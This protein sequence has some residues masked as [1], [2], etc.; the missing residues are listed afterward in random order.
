M[1]PDD[2]ATQQEE[3][4]REMAL[5]NRKLELPKIGRCYN[6]GEGIKPNANFCDADCRKDYERRTENAKGK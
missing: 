1:S 4:L 6:C 2:Q 3:L 5:K